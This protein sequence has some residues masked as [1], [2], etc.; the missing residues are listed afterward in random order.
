LKGTT[1]AVV[2]LLLATA[3]VDPNLRDQYSVSPLIRACEIGNIPIVKR[4]LARDDVDITAS[5]DDG[6]IPLLTACELHESPEIV[7]I[8]LAKDGISVNLYDRR[9]RSR[10][11]GW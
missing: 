11:C 2:E 9:G 5:S 6:W 10:R 4:L 7:D 1:S 8:L 3:N